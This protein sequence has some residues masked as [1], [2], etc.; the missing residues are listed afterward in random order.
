MSLVCPKCRKVYKHINNRSK[1][2]I[3]NCELKLATYCECGCGKFAKP[4]NRYIGSHNRKGKPSPLKGT[5]KPKS[6]PQICACGKCGL[7]T[8]PGRKY[9]VGHNQRGCKQSDKEKENRKKSHQK[10]LENL[11]KERRLE[12]NQNISNAK[13]T[14]EGKETTRLASFKGKDKMIEKLKGHTPYNKIRDEDKTISHC[15]QCGEEMLLR[16]C[17]VTTRKFCSRKCQNKYRTGRPKGNWNPN[18]ILKNNQ[19]GKGISGRYKGLLFRSSLELSFLVQADKIGDKI[20]PE[21][22]IIP[23]EKYLDP[24]DQT[25]FNSQGKQRYIPDF[26]VNNNVLVEI[27]PEGC[28]EL[29]DDNFLINIAKMIAL[30]NFCKENGFIPAIITDIGMGELVLTDKKI[31]EIPFQHIEFFKEKHRERYL[32]KVDV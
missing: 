27:K 19:A 13:Q 14:P 31:R 15:L 30:N 10:Y 29:E 18:S 1:N 16:P 3:A 24:I 20:L 21:P 25:V 17:H 23:L 28:F 11:S 2:H 32:S 4:G 5:G 7:M 8:K 22:F 12:I 6:P 26:L 9:I